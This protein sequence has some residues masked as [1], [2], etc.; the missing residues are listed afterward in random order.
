MSKWLGP[1][2]I[3]SVFGIGRTMTYQLLKEYE[4]AGNEV[5]RI[6]K[7]TRVNEESFTNYLLKRG[8]A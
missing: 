7:L 5:L 6:G 1:A 2:D 3:R 8:K 4:Q